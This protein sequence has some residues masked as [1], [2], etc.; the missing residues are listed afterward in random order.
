M[1]CKWP[2]HPTGS[3]RGTSAGTHSS[4]WYL[5]PSGPM[6]SSGCALIIS[7]PVRQVTRRNVFESTP[8]GMQQ[9]SKAVLHD[10]RRD[11]ECRDDQQNAAPP[12]SS[13]AS[14]TRSGRERRR[15]CRSRRPAFPQAE[16]PSP[17]E[18]RIQSRPTA[19]CE[20]RAQRK[21]G[22]RASSA[23]TFPGRKT[24]SSDS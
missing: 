12:K 5:G 6:P 9:R 24:C 20:Q 18:R 14:K 22:G 19:V 8:L 21:E 2:Y 17:S 13:T 10:R 1:L 7:R 16:P 11:Q 15:P 23:R 4:K 3:G